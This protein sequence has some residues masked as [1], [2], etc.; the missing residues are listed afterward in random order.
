MVWRDFLI[1]LKGFKR[2]A[3]TASVQIP[4]GNAKGASSTRYNAAI[5]SSTRCVVPSV[6][7]ST[8]WRS[9]IERSHVS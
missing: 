9:G 8:T 4:V 3:G 1:D 2:T 5:V 6:A 7:Q